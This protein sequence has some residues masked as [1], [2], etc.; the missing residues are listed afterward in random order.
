MWLATSPSSVEAIGCL[1]L[2]E[3]ADPRHLR[4]WVGRERRVIGDAPALGRQLLQ[5]L[6]QDPGRGQ[7]LLRGDLRHRPSRQLPPARDQQQRPGRARPAGKLR[8]G[9]VVPGLPRLDHARQRVPGLSIEVDEARVRKEGVQKRDAERVAGGRVDQPQLPLAGIVDSLLEQPAKLRA[10]P[11]RR[12]LESRP[13]P[14]GGCCRSRVPTGRGPPPT[15][16]RRARARR[17]R[18]RPATCRAPR[19]GT[20]PPTAAGRR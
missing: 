9:D 18:A 3:R 15:R 2:Q 13:P 19:T 8:I 4:R 14:C 17:V 7:P 16:A 1:E 12:G 6:E 20:S 10:Q 5:V 11:A